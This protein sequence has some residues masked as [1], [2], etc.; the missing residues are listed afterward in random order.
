MCGISKHYLNT[1][2]CSFTEAYHPK[3]TRNYYAHITQF[4]KL[5]RIYQGKA[6]LSEISD[7]CWKHF[8]KYNKHSN[9]Y[10]SLKYSGIHVKHYEYNNVISHSVFSTK[11]FNLSENEENKIKMSFKNVL[12]QCSSL[13]TQ[14]TYF[15]TRLSYKK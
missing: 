12:S 13:F 11:L 8:E 3:C 4:M 5:L 6:L 9:L 15:P 14:K 10:K 7:E 2:V 1:S